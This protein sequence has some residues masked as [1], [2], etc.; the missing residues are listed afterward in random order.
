MCRQLLGSKFRYLRKGRYLTATLWYKLALVSA[1]YLVSLCIA[2]V[3]GATAAGAVGLVVTL[4]SLLSVV[5]LAGGDVKAL[6]VQAEPASSLASWL[7]HSTLIAMAFAG[8]ISILTVLIGDAPAVAGFLSKV[9]SPGVVTI[10]T[11]GCIFALRVLM[12]ETIR[13]LGWT[14]VYNRISLF[15]PFALLIVFLAKSWAAPSMHDGVVVVTA[16]AIILLVGLC[17]IWPQISKSASANVGMSIRRALNLQLKLY[18]SSLTVALLQADLMVLSFVAPV[19]EVGLYAVATRLATL[20]KLP[21]VASGVEYAPK[22]AKDFSPSAVSVAISYAK[23]EAKRAAIVAVPLALV[24]C[25]VAGPFLGLY[26][27]EFRHATLPA[28][29][30]CVAAGVS[31]CLG[32]AGLF[33]MMAQRVREQQVIFALA[34]VVQYACMTL[35]YGEWGLLGAAVGS[36][37]GN[38]LRLALCNAA[39]RRYYGSGVTAL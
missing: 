19:D 30:L 13:G 14:G 34:A 29:V 26:G 8:I 32:Q 20:V 7:R 37:A 9:G 10:W 24:M 39:V 3:G 2:R 15:A 35:L 38:I 31:A 23:S 17:A 21:I 33:L 25:V 4:A 28:I 11:C 5:C 36:A 22:I 27:D 12:L 6:R 18:G 16:Q 1:N